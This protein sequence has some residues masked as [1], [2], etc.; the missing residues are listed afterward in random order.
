MSSSIP[1]R[2]DLKS[3]EAGYTLL[4]TV[5]LVAMTLIT[6][7]VVVLDIKTQGKR[8][9]EEEMI[10]RGEQFKKAIR[11]Y[12]QKFGKYPQSMDDLVK[13]TNGVRFLRKAYK[14]PVNPEGKWRFIYVTPAGALIGSVR[15]TSLQEMALLDQM[16]MRGGAAGAIPGASAMA[17][18]LGA[19]GGLGGAG[20][21]GFGG[22]AGGAAGATGATALPPCQPTPPTTNPDSPPPDSPEY[23]PQTSPNTANCTPQNGAAGTQNGQDSNGFGGFGLESNGSGGL[24][25]QLGQQ[26]GQAL[27]QPLETTTIG[28]SIIGV[29]S[30]MDQPS[31][32]VYKLAKKYKQWE[33]IY[34]PLE[35]QQ[36]Q[37]AGA[38]GGLTG[39][40]PSNE[41]GS[42][43]GGGLGGNQGSSPFGPTPQPSGPELQQ[44]PSQ[45]PQQ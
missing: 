41:M 8:E 17:G 26:L 33:F 27:G 6:S 14:D 13:P 31:L 1:I 30:M 25:Q 5:F 32:K 7:A 45:A 4:F 20:T 15:Y 37:G 43:I 9:K 29:G 2:R 36:A 18:L 22:T 35:Q 28:G 24:G 16:A 11:R 38:S 23:P 3:R 34:N 12:S 19:A 10:W 44:P 40:T 42:P 21:T 39:A